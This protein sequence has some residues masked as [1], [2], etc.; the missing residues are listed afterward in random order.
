M[1]RGTVAGAEWAAAEAW[2][3]RPPPR[4]EAASVRLED[5][6]WWDPEAGLLELEERER[7]SR[8]SMAAAKAEVLAQLRQEG[9][10]SALS[11]MG[12]DVAEERWEHD[13]KRLQAA[14]A[15]AQTRHNLRE[16]ERLLDVWRQSSRSYFEAI[17]ARADRS[18]GGGIPWVRGPDEGSVVASTERENALIWRDHFAKL[19][20]WQVMRGFDMDA[21]GQAQIAAQLL[22]D[23]LQEQREEGRSGERAEALRVLRRVRDPLEAA[24]ARDSRRRRPP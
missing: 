4:L 24:P 10:A 11:Q 13:L 7:G 6:P 15:T 17:K 22:K 5:Q 19:G 14:C 9:G 21:I 1:G 12:A 18:E 20:E 2:R 3:S 16:A 23:R 8:R